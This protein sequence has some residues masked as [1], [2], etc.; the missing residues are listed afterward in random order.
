[1]KTE[2]I[3]LV[4]L[5]ITVALVYSGSLAYA[6]R[7]WG[8]DPTKKWRHFLNKEQYQVVRAQ[9]AQVVLS[10]APRIQTQLLLWQVAFDDFE[11]NTFMT[12][13]LEEEAV[14]KSEA[15]ILSYTMIKSL[16]EIP[17]YEKYFRQIKDPSWMIRGGP[18]FLSTGEGRLYCRELVS[19]F[20][21][22]GVE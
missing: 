15:R 16:N 9:V 1:M 8:T 22:R 18:G 21:E 14:A 17:E 10:Y 7:T 11:D 6:E 13:H 19:L 2:D 3:Q 12:H 20:I 5:L 4:A